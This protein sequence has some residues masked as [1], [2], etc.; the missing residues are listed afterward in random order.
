MPLI[1]DQ[2]QCFLFD[3]RLFH[4]STVLEIKDCVRICANEQLRSVIINIAPHKADEVRIRIIATDACHTD[5]FTLSGS[6]RDGIVSQRWLDL[7][8]IILPKQVA[9]F[10]RGPRVPKPN[11][12]AQGTTSNALVSTDRDIKRLPK[13][14]DLERDGSYNG[15]LFRKR[16]TEE[17]LV[18]HHSVSRLRSACPNEV[19]IAGAPQIKIK[20]EAI[21]QP[22]LLWQPCLDPT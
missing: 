10:R 16:K 15:S 9:K 5:V 12:P 7:A 2:G 20:S 8:R 4:V 19:V 3:T 22:T 11:A 6:G 13:R 1:L 14:E 18:P 21:C 17:M